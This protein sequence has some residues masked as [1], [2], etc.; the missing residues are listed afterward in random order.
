MDLILI[1]DSYAPKINSGSI[2]VGDLAKALAQSG[3][4]TTVV[5]FADNM[6]DAF[7]VTREDGV[8]VIRIGIGDR[9][10]S[11]IH[12]AL[13]ERSFSKRIIK[14]LKKIDD[15]SYDA[16][17]CYSP[18]IFFGDAVGWLKKRK[19]VKAYMI[20][21]D[22]FPKWAL[23]AGLLR[24]GPVYQY[25]RYIERKQYDVVDIIGV[26]STAD[27]EYFEREAGHKNIKLEVL[28][29]WSSPIGEIDPGYGKSVLDPDKINIIFGGNVGDAQDI[30]SLVKGM[31]PNVLGDH[32]A[33]TLVGDGD[34]IK[35]VK[36][37][38]AAR[39]IKGIVFSPRVDRDQYLS[40]LSAADIGLISLN[41]KLKSHNYPLKMI[42]Y[43]QLGKPL[44]ASVN[45]GNEIIDLINAKDI[46]RVS[47][48]G[49]ANAFNANI[50]AMIEDGEI[51]QRQGRNAKALF[52]T[53]FTVE[54]AI[55]QICGALE[56]L[57][58]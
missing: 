3:H 42:G 2:I 7:T 43:M 32:A 57:K 58:A 18:S 5:T 27:L 55:K 37:E 47:I 24:E 21:R 53:D 28:N 11:R 19:P 23:D 13:I 15:L 35:A 39:K 9:K 22:I 54:A 48:A 30:L 34:Q 16:I 20:M 29:N 1:A 44:L 33:L 25:F 49:D 8:E 26:E 52:D 51:R 17:I 38:V 45:P 40:V 12:R 31:D 6:S 56:R 10:K 36:A 46:G 50:K 4:N 14:T 41:A